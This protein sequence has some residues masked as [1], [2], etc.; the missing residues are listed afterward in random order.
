[1]NFLIFAVT[2]G[3]SPLLSNGIFSQTVFLF[4]VIPPEKK[5]RDLQ[6]FIRNIYSLK[7][8]LTFLY[9]C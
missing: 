9:L 6:L 4:S 2:I 5:K 1:M 3:Q 7:I 8:A